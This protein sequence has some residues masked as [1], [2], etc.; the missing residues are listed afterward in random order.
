[1]LITGSVS[2]YTEITNQAI[3][4]APAIYPRAQM[5]VR[6]VRWKSQE[7]DL[8]T[9]GDY[10]SPGVAAAGERARTAATYGLL[11]SNAMVN[12]LV[13][14]TAIRVFT[15]RPEGK[16]SAGSVEP[17]NRK[18]PKLVRQINWAMPAFGII[19]HWA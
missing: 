19:I 5:V 12:V 10:E 6:H 16:N 17:H 3:E 9:A 4:L 18:N 8:H 1:M 2:L 7:A 13:A 15:F 14:A 11:A